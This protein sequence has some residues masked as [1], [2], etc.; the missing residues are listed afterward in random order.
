MRI[1]K[2]CLKCIREDVFT[3]GRW[4]LKPQYLEPLREQVEGLLKQYDK[5]RL[6]SY[7]I[8]EVHRIVKSIDPEL[9]KLMRLRWVTNS[10]IKR[11]L[12]RFS[13]ASLSK[14]IQWAVWANSLDFRTAGVGYAYKDFRSFYHRLNQRLDVD[15]RQNIIRLVKKAKNILYILDNVGEIGFDRL[16]IEAISKGKKVVAAVRA[17]IMTSDVTKDD[18]LFFGIQ[19]FAEII[20]SGPDTLGLLKEELSREILFR[21]KKADLVIFKGQANYYFFSQYPNITKA[22]VVG[23]FTTKCDLVARKFCLQGKASIATRLGGQA[24]CCKP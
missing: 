3:A 5:R 4:L 15:E 7:Y 14:K 18:A 9:K 12:K 13:R 22:P 1:H 24:P 20:E 11:L 16:L 2:N 21:F 10:Q 6:P 19:K 23:L 17:G 8:T